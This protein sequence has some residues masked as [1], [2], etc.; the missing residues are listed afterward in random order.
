MRK[1]LAVILILAACCAAAVAAPAQATTYQFMST[2]GLGSGENHFGPSL[3]TLT[4]V[5]GGS[6]GAAA[7]CVGVSG[8][9]EYQVCGG[10]YQQVST[11]YI[12]F[13][14]T[15]YLH[16]HS[17]WYSYFNAWENGS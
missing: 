6:V 3:S 1:R 10:E 8:H 7:S 15:G 4:S 13:S 2:T 9:P 5:W 14:G 12:G 16:N 11:G 17:T